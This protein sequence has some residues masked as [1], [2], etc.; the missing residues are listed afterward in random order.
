[1]SDEKIGKVEMPENRLASKVR[2]DGPW[3]VTE[4]VLEKA[5]ES[6]AE[7]AD[8]FSDD[9]SNDVS[10]LVEAMKMIKA[11]GG[12]QAAGLK[13]SFHIAHNLKGKGSTFN[14]DLLTTVS[15]Q[16]CRFIEDVA[17]P[18]APLSIEVLELNIG[19]INIIQSQNLIGDGGEAGEE[20][21]KGLEKVIRKR[22]KSQ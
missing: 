17:P 6:L 14:Y 21:M 20:L 9:L 8:D 13:K 5:Q 22:E 11:G 4:K 18:L 10:E 1:M 15:D 7:L 12:D 16:L 3:V 19:A 2:T